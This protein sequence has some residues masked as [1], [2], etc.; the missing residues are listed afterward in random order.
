MGSLIN[1]L[2]NR[3][4]NRSK[5]GDPTSMQ[6]LQA[7]DA[8]WCG[9]DKPYRKCH[10]SEDRKREKDLGLSRKSKSICDAFTWKPR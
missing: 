6:D 1:W 9:S 4:S 8:C 2:F 10:W 5:A 3:K 7:N